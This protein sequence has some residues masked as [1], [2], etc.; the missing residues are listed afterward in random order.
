MLLRNMRHCAAAPLSRQNQP[1]SRR[2]ITG[3]RAAAG[4]P[5]APVPTNLCIQRKGPPM[6]FLQRL[7]IAAGLLTSVTALVA[8]AP[9]TARQWGLL[10][11]AQAQS[12]QSEEDRK[13]KERQAPKGQGQ[14]PK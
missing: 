13:R 9:Q 1:C 3:P 2:V 4:L 10:D 6:I 12:P 7:G 14:E 5:H 8:T 11:Q